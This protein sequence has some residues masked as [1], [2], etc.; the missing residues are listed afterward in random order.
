M[1]TT[2]LLFVSTFFTVFLLGLQNLNVVNY[3]YGLAVITSFGISWANYYL[4][5]IIP[6][7]EFTPVRVV[8]Y[9]AGG[10]LGVVSSM[11]LFQFIFP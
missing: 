8:L 10:A 7:T 1:R 11:A 2:L 4:Y 5:K 9:C 3:K 6:T